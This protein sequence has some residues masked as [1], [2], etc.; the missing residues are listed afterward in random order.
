MEKSF[1]L[2]FH[3]K[4]PKKSTNN[5]WPIYLRITVNGASCEVSIKR[6]C[7]RNK[8]HTAMGRV[9][10]RTDFA[11]SLNN[12]LDILE[13][14]VHACRSKLIECNQEITAIA[15][16]NLLLDKQHRKEQRFLLEIFQKHNEQMAA[17]VGQ[18]YAAATLKRYTTAYGHTRAFLQWKFNIDDI[19]VKAL[20]YEFICDYE[21]WL[22]SIRRCGHNSTIKYLTNFR[23]IVNRCVRLGWLA[24]DPFMGYKMTKKEVVRA[25]LTEL[26]LERVMDKNFA[27]ERLAIVRDIFIFSCYTG[28]A[29]VDVKQLKQS[30]IV[31]GIDGE[32]WIVC[33]RQKTDHPVKIPLLPSALRIIKKYAFH[34]QCLHSGRVL[35]VLSNQKMNAYLKEIADVCGLHR[36]LTFHIARHTFATTVTLSNGVPIETVSKMLGHRDLKTTQLYAKVLDIKISHDMQLLKRKTQRQGDSAG[37]NITEVGN[38]LL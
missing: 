2:C 10:G 35:P 34:P 3:L 6:A 27:I 1:G 30:D 23:K 28:L 37:P 24:K 36:M 17:L 8:W 4:M 25:A 32:E 15:L 38:A 26:E 20:N 12:Y 14:K 7:P 33:R 9:E 21:F 11:K 22:K 31:V 5:E 13:R 16:K 18:E 19:D 29:Y